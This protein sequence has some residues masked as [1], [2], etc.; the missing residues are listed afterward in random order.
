MYT[1]GSKYII[2]K[3][4]CFSF[5]EGGFCG[6]SSGS[7]VCRNTHLGVLSQQRAKR[8]GYCIDVFLLTCRQY[9]I[10]QYL[11]VLP[12]SIPHRVY[13]ILLKQQIT[14]INHQAAISPTTQ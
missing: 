5:S 9:Q 11:R 8:P 2:S 6:I 1:K 3:E 12:V 7:S 13:P 10:S 4:F 14:E